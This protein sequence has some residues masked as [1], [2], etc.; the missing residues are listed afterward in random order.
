MTG[1]APVSPLRRLFRL[2]GRE[3]PVEEDIAAEFEAHLALK[4]EALV[5][6]GLPPDQARREAERRFGTL[7]RFAA[8]CRTIDRAERKERRRREWWSGAMQDLRLAARGLLR[9]PAFAASAVL[10]LATGIGLN[11]TVFTLLRGVVLRPLPFPRSDRL[12]AVYSSNPKAGWPTFAA[13]PTD[14]YDWEREVRSFQAMVAWSSFTAAA[15]GMGPAEQVPGVSVT[16]GFGA[17]SGVAPILGRSF[18]AA[19]FATG[20]PRVALL[21]EEA[22]SSRFGHDPG[23]LAKSWT[24]DGERYQIVGVMPRGFAFP[25]G[26]TDVW[27]PFRT[28]RDVATQRGAHYVYVTGRLADNATI[29][30]A[31]TELVTLADRIARTYPKS[32]A[33]WTVALLP[34]H[35]DV[36]G[37]VRPTLLLLMTGVGLLLILACANVANLVLVRA[38]GRSGE[39][40]V[41]SALGAGRGRLLWHEAGEVLV[42]VGLGALGAVPVAALGA[43][44][45]RRFAPEGVPR[46]GEV[47][48]DPQALLFTLGVTAVAA[49]LVGLAPARRIAR[50][51][52]RTAIA[53][54]GV[55]GVGARSGL[56]RWLVA[57]ETAVA[58]ALLA[59]AGVL[60]KSKARLEHVD[61]G[62]D[63]ISTM[64]AS[65]S[66]PDKTYATGDAIVRFDAD[67]LGRVRRMPGVQAASL[68]FGLPLSGFGY[69]S[70]FTIDSV[71]VPDDVHQS[72]QLRVVSSDYFATLR[73]PIIAGR[74]FTADDRRGGRP[75]VVI[76]AAAARQFWP[77]GRFL[78]RF[79]RVAAQPGP[80][81]DSP[82]GE[83]VGVAGDVRERG[84]DREPRPI[85]YADID[86]VP[87][88]GVTMVLRTSVTPLSLAPELRRIVAALDP[89]LPL[90]DVRTM[91]DVVRAATASQRFRAWLMGFFALLAA[92]LAG[93]G[94]YSVVSHIVAQRGREIGLRRALGASDSRVVAEVV[95][96]GMR[97]AGIG[98]VL[99]LALGG[100]ITTRLTR[101]LYQ[102]RP[103][104]PLV[105]AL[106]AALFLGVAFIACWVPARRATAADPVSVLRGE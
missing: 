60:V 102:V 17:V 51:D 16:S 101:L 66:L 38:I 71:A 15:T 79:V 22:W 7:E 37:D 11:A 73:I 55:R 96:A 19:E 46:I 18:S 89:E 99:G 72:A 81:D 75:V 47:R 64:V 9:A 52:L 40:A 45:V 33:G 58:L 32:S 14:F 53:R 36:V 65:F 95:A 44:M 62:F 29:D 5:R 20:A 80:E 100:F 43:G 90:T 68:V 87:V 103:A 88:S 23:V 31:R 94:V 104:D 91:E 50:L 98:A 106:A 26:K 4:T 57:V 25:V 27:I 6:T 86:Q 74:G 10:V 1:P 78:G 67:L 42:L 49:L 28:P 13:S 63:P 48:L 39:V 30:G 59:V 97:D 61:P 12:V 70:S 35:E 76:S 21:S 34:L 92:T 82:Q 69:S 3:P 77:D 83:I 84:L 85:V 2:I 105:L 93:L 41:R 54:A 24:L 56:H 8:E